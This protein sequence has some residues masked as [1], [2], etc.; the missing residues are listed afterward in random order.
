[1]VIK[2]V[3]EIPS[4]NIWTCRTASMPVKMR[5]FEVTSH[6]NIRQPSQRV[7]CQKLLEID[8]K[9]LIG[10]RWSI[11][12]WKEKI[13]AYHNR[14]KTNLHHWMLELRRYHWTRQYIGSEWNQ[15]WQISQNIPLW[16][17]FTSLSRTSYGYLNL[18]RGARGLAE[19]KQGRT[20]T[21]S[22]PGLVQ[23]PYCVDFCSKVD[24]IDRR[25]STIFAKD[26]FSV[27]FLV[28]DHT[29][30]E[31]LAKMQTIRTNSW[32]YGWRINNIAHASQKRF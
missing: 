1:M 25:N 11:K 6:N 21:F 15:K 22:L 13:E 28:Y 24:W 29:Q 30:Q 3:T 8:K 9:R 7:F 2:N 14:G 26:R 18:V 4:P 32:K 19:L 12:S 23:R 10:I 16:L 17:H 31:N 20:S 27:L 5:K